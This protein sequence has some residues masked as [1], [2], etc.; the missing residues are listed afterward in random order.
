MDDLQ[1][2]L[3][4]QKAYY[5]ARAAE[6]DE[7]FERRG[8]YDHGEALN[9]QWVN[10]A[11]IARAA[12]H[13]LGP[14][15]HAIE[16]ACGTG[17]WTQELAGMAKQVTALDASAEMLTINRARVDSANV[18]YQKVDLFEWEPVVPADLVF[19]GFW[20]S[21]VPAE[22]LASFL[23]KVRRSIRTGGQVFVID[24]RADQ[25]STAKDGTVDVDAERVQS[26]RLNDGRTFRIV[27]TY[28]SES[29]LSSLLT[30]AGF[31]PEVFTTG[32]F[33]IC[34]QGAAQ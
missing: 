30:Q 9:A 15:D 29:H 23:F 21:H 7:W 28:Y 19:M 17:I 5:R 16:L 20:L 25:Q 4:E 13:R 24:S 1:K 3:D 18:T 32:R 33:F 26:R 27:K 6:Y 10:E 14:V 31:R 34:A 11:G 2:L 12:L 22:R 8:R